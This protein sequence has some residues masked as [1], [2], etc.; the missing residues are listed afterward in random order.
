MKKMKFII[1]GLSMFCLV[2]CG[3]KENTEVKEDENDNHIIEIENGEE[4]EK[5]GDEASNSQ[6]TGTIYDI[7][8]K[9]SE[10]ENEAAALEK[11]L[12]ED[13]SLKQTDMNDISYEIYM[14]WDDLLNDMWN[15]IKGILDEE[16]MNDLLEEQREWIDEKEA[17]VEKAGEAYAGGSMA[18][19]VK[20][21]KAAELTKERVYEL[22]PYLS[23]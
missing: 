21:Q 16:A 20:N 13:A 18:P 12:S 17:E 7:E 8:S 11:K 9:L 15:E 2:A 23:K 3:I 5:Q 22:V 10:A 6:E 19:L 4:Q 1:L 14:I